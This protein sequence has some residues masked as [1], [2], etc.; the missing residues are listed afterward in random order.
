MSR[1]RLARAVVV[2]AALVGLAAIASQVPAQAV[3]APVDPSSL[4][5]GADIGIPYVRHHVIHDG[6]VRVEVPRRHYTDLWATARGYLLEDAARRL[7]HIS[8]GGDVRRLARH[9]HTVAVSA[10][11]RRVAWGTYEDPDFGPPVHI[12]VAD[13]DH[14]HVV[15]RRTFHRVLYVGAVTQ[16]R[17]LLATSWAAPRAATWW[18]HLRGDR[19]SRLVGQASL[20]ADVRH[21]RAVF[22]VGDPDAFCNRVAPLSHPRRTLWH[23]CRSIVKA[24]SPNGR[25]A[26]ATRTYFDDTGTDFW[27]V[28]NGT[29][30]RRVAR[31]TGRLDWNAAWEDNRH[32]LTS[33][34]GE[35]GMAAV[36]RCNVHGRCERATRLWDT[37]WTGWPPYYVAPP[38]LLAHDR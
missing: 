12:T 30:G 33:A 10:D 3:R 28:V 4:A 21:D 29:T 14:R 20:G 8:H 13:P 35:D 31:V 27:A 37:G 16:G 1:K 34:M 7:V 22:S 19:L 11:G 23:S 5:R 36:V 9:V 2:V 15:A 38:V 25:R 32:F 24:W 26:I 18:W 6:D 17:A